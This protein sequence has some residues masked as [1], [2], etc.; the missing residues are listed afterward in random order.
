MLG[1]T[2]DR[3]L[4]GQEDRHGLM[5]QGQPIGRRQWVLAAVERFEQPLLR[6][7]V[8][9]VGEL[10][11]ARDA[12][13]HAFLRLCE[14]EPSELEG[15]VGPWLFRVCRNKAMDRLRAR[16]RTATADPTELCVGDCRET[17]PAVEIERNDLSAAIRGL[18]ARIPANQREALTLWTEGCGYREIAQVLGTSEGNVRVLMHRALKQVRNHP[19]VRE[20]AMPSPGDPVGTSDDRVREAPMS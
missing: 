6:Y 12:V 9:L 16:R 4:L 20:L 11:A 2:R 5:S 13:Q 15:R 17:D 8:R 18:L 3:R 19:L 7:A 10:D 14:C 1:N